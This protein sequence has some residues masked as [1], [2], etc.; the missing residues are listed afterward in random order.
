MEQ[1]PEEGKPAETDGPTD[2]TAEDG[3]AHSNPDAP[4]EAGEQS[5]QGRPTSAEEAPSSPPIHE[6]AHAIEYQ[7]AL[8]APVAP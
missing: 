5:A 1:P 6:P 7:A 4:A 3:A 2:L 8:H